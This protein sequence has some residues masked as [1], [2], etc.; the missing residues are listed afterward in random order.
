VWYFIGFN[1]EYLRCKGACHDSQTDPL[2][3][4]LDVAALEVQREFIRTQ[5]LR[6]VARSGQQASSIAKLPDDPFVSA[7]TADA[8]F[9]INLVCLFMKTHLLALL[10]DNCW[11]A[12]LCFPAQVVWKRRNITAFC[13]QLLKPIKSAVLADTDISVNPKIGRYIGRSLMIFLPFGW[14]WQVLALLS[15]QCRLARVRNHS[16]RYLLVGMQ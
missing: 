13:Q 1:A 16:D 9:M 15:Q 6:A 5:H 3:A 12:S 10:Q 7:A 8:C 2:D 14:K 11:L 4:S